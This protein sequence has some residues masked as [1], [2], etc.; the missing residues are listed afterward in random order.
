MKDQ[1]NNISDLVGSD[2]GIKY[3]KLTER[4]VFGSYFGFHHIELWVSNAYQAAM[5]YSTHLGFKIIAYAGLETGIQA[6]TAHVLR[7][8]Q[9]TLVVKSPLKPEASSITQFIA[10]HGDGVRDVAFTVE[11]VYAT[12]QHA[13]SKGAKIVQPPTTLKDDIGEVIIATIEAYGSTVHSFIQR[14]CYQGIFLPGYSAT[15]H[16]LVNHFADQLPSTH[17]GRID[18][19]VANQPQGQMNTVVDFYVESLGFRRFW[20]VDDKLL[21]TGTSGLHSIVV[22]DYDER[23]KIP[24]NQPSIELKGRSQTQEFVD[25]HGAAGIQHVAICVEDLAKTVAAL[26]Q[27]G[28]HVLPVPKEYYDGLA[29]VL[30]EINLDL[31]INLETMRKLD[32]VID[33]DDQGFILQIFTKPLESRPTLFFEFMQRNNHDGFGAGNFKSLFSAIEAQQ[34]LR[35]TL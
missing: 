2:A 8:G 18:H 35:G 27:R 16:V 31:G 19:V 15:E 22:C 7:A 11:D 10:E 20:S 9:T 33:Y 1:A 12:F 30:A 25:F 23:I 32:I 21:Q 4:P 14:N 26:K 3:E 29:P 5:F 28:C 13:R 6:Y 34:K 17:I 24:V